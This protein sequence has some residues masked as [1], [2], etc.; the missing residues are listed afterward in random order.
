MNVLIFL[1]ALAAV[2]IA[3]PITTEPRNSTDLQ[4]TDTALSLAPQT[5]GDGPPRGH[6]WWWGKNK[7]RPP[8]SKRDGSSDQLDAPAVEIKPRDEPKTSPWSPLLGN[9][10]QARQLD[11]SPIWCDLMV[12]S[13]K[14]VQISHF[15]NFL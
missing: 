7:P 5:A 4:G 11:L 9:T 12:E 6:P 1:T 15:C 14:K 10:K 13:C 8:M 2:V 3:S